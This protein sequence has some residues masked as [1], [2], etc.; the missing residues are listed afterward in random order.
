MFDADL[1]KLYGVAPKVFNQTIQR[2]RET[3]P[4]DFLFRLE[5]EEVAHLRSQIVTSSS[6]GTFVG[7]GGRR[8]LP[9]AFT[10]H[11]AIMAATILRSR[12][13]VAMSV[14]VVR[15]FVRMQEDLLANAALLAAEKKLITH[16]VLLRDVFEKLRPLLAP[17]TA[18]PRREIGFHST[19][20]SAGRGRPRTG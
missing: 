17:L 5:R 2:N 8:T 16:D 3:L 9:W 6:A 4:A 20:G 11:G 18:P 13:A 14:F 19:V 10:E 7:H 1:A 15:A 12:L